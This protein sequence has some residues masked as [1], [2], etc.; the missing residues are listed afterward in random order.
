MPNHNPVTEQ[1]LNKMLDATAD[2]GLKVCMWGKG[3]V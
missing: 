2:Q 3:G 1:R